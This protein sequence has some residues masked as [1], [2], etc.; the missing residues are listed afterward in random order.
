MHLK[1]LSDAPPM[2]CTYIIEFAISP[3]VHSK[4]GIYKY[5]MYVFENSSITLISLN[6]LA[7]PHCRKHSTLPAS[8]GYGILPKSKT[9]IPPP[10][11]IG[12]KAESLILSCIVSGI[13]IYMS[14]NMLRKASRKSIP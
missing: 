6:H 5:C 9:I 10:F 7:F 3:F 13:Q 12:K 2:K 8:Y 14:C 4:I 1:R 11:F